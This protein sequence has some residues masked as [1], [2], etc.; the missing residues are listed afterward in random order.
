MER[1]DQV[2]QGSPTKM[3]VRWGCLNQST[4]V[5]EEFGSCWKIERLLWSS[6]SSI[7]LETQ[8]DATGNCSRRLWSCSSL[9][10]NDIISGQCQYIFSILLWIDTFCYCR[11][12]CSW[13]MCRQTFNPLPSYTSLSKTV[14]KCTWILTSVFKSII[15]LSYS[16]SGVTQKALKRLNRSEQEPD[17]MPAILC[18]CG[19]EIVW[20][21]VETN[22]LAWLR[23]SSIG[24]EGQRRS[25]SLLSLCSI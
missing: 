13:N 18:Q 23:S 12:S 9:H 3:W 5:R 7:K 10:I 15:L 4:G 17:S 6:Y 2:F 22:R 24:K 21:L 1:W 20:T 19:F 8:H 11:A 14:N 16:A 25:L